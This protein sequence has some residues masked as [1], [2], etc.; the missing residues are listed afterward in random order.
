MIINKKL[1]KDKLKKRNEFL[2]FR[3]L[4][5]AGGGGSAINN[6]VITFP[7][8]NFSKNTNSMYLGVL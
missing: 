3:A 6:I 8:L 7:S 5:Q 4:S 1:D 2:R